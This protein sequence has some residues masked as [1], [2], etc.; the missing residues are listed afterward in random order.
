MVNKKNTTKILTLDKYK[1][2]GW[3]LSRLSMEL[4]HKLISKEKI[5]RVLEFGSGQSTYFFNDC[6]I[7][8]ISF[9][10]DITYA[11]KTD[12][13]IIKEIIQFSD[14]DFN[15]IIEGKTNYYD[16]L[17]NASKPKNIHSRMQNCF[18]NILPDDIKGVFD[19]FIIDGPH[20]NGRSIS[21]ELIKNHLSPTSFIFVDDFN[22]YPFIDHLKLSF[23]DAILVD[24]YSLNR[25]NWQ[26]YKII[27]K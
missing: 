18:Y 11:A 13:V 8:C 24:E 1:Y 26:L 27:L 25:D 19:L 23:P 7:E 3:G 4:L 22:H 15:N 21:F 14:L 17:A 9:D 12:N 16:V 20:G 6:G 10:N 2:T 5:N